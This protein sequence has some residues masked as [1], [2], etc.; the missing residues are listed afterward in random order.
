MIQ[1][2]VLFNANIAFLAIPP[3]LPQN[4]EISAS[5]TASIVSITL[6]LS[7]VIFGQLLGK[8]LQ[9]LLQEQT[10]QVVRS[11]YHSLI[12]SMNMFISLIRRTISLGGG[13]HK[14][15]LMGLQ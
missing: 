5:A 8:R 14:E 11:S 10:P 4:G 9:A 1:A 3:V 6:S 13:V 2:A 15:V 12:T 7:S